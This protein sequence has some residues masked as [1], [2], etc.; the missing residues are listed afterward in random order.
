MV[1]VVIG[2]EPHERAIPIGARLL[3]WKVLGVLLVRVAPVPLELVHDLQVLVERH[4]HLRGKGKGP[5][6]L[7][8]LRL[9]YQ[10]TSTVISVGGAASPKASFL[11]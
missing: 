1:L 8:L 11:M 3:Q 10:L 7:S 6:P 2:I 4:I 9:G 5:K